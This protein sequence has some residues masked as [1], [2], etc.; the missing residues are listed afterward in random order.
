MERGKET[1]KRP[2]VSAVVT[3]AGASTR[4]GGTCKQLMLLRG[5][6]VLFLYLGLVSL[7][8]YG[9]TGHPLPQ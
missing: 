8:I 1:D 2:F 4:M 3:A 7:A 5:M 9:L 6:P